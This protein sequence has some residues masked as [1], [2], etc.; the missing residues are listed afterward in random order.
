VVPLLSLRHRE[1]QSGVATQVLSKS[2]DCFVAN[3][4][5]NDDYK[6]LSFVE[7]KAG[8]LLFSKYFLSILRDFCGERFLSV[9]SVF[10]GGFT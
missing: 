8:F 4:P 6:K 5:R 7:G 1:P 10:I 3:A 9:S 2:L